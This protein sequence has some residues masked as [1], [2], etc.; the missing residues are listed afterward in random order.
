MT[1]TQGEVFI[2]TYPGG[3]QASRRLT[4][5][6]VA[7]FAAGG[8][9]W[10][11]RAATLTRPTGAVHY[12]PTCLGVERRALART[13]TDTTCKHCLMAR[14]R[15]LRGWRWNERLNAEQVAYITAVLGDRVA[16]FGDVERYGRKR[17]HVRSLEDTP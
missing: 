15:D 11:E 1:L 2:V 10:A 9:P 4:A 14:A 12:F 7:A 13:I 3:T 8:N 16:G 17:W 5:E 6:E